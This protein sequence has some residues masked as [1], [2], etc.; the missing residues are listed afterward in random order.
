MFLLNVYAFMRCWMERFWCG[1]GPEYRTSWICRIQKL[2][3]L[4]YL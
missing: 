3:V 4:V 2:R 1:R